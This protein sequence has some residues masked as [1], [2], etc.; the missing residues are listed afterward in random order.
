MLLSNPKHYENFK[1]L[2]DKV[3]QNKTIIFSDG[4]K[5]SYNLLYQASRHEYKAQA[6][7]ERCNKLGAPTICFVLSEHGKVFGGYISIDWHSSFTK[8]F[9]KSRPDEK[10]FIFSLTHLTK[11]RLID[12]YTG[13]ATYHNRSRIWS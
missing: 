6:F 13:D 2:V 7:H 10:A 12:P 9:G 11:H 5:R 4:L 8:L 1:D 3:L